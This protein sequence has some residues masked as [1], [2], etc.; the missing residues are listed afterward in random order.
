MV[1]TITDGVI[2]PYNLPSR[3]S[4][5]IVNDLPFNSA[6]VDFKSSRSLVTSTS[7]L[8]FISSNRLR[9]D[10]LADNANPLGIK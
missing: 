9:L 4:A 5:V 6:A 8:S 2:E 3:E 7:A 10:L 1:S